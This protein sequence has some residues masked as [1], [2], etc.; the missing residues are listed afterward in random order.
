M[1]RFRNTKNQ[2][3]DIQITTKDGSDTDNIK[4]SGSPFTT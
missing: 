3:Y 2:L 1:S 4:L